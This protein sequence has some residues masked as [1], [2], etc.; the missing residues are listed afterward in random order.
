[1]ETRNNLI[2]NIKKAVK[3]AH[4]NKIP[5]IYINSAFRKSD[6]IFYKYINY[7]EQAMDGDQNSQI[8]KELEPKPQ[9]YIL[10]KR[11]YDSFWKSGLKKLLKRLKV[12]EIYLA[13]IQT[14]CC[15]RETA[16]T[17]AHLGYDVYILEDCCQTNREFGQIAALRFFKNC[18]K[19]IITTHDLTSYFK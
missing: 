13:G 19:G 8:I 9:D 3:I 2:K 12:Q 15:V 16:V 18:T 11:G 4:Q 5:V 1:L 7:R 10:K 6:P 14:D 17:A